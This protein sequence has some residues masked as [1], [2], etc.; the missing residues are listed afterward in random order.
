MGKAASLLLIGKL[1]MSFPDDIIFQTVLLV[2]SYC[3][4]ELWIFR[5]GFAVHVF[6]VNGLLV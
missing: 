1:T 4:P 6:A 5:L 2:F 3:L